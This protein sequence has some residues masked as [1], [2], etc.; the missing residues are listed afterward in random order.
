MRVSCATGLPSAVI[1]TDEVS[2]A[3]ISR[4]KVLGAFAR[5]ARGL[6]VAVAE[7]GVDEE[8]SGVVLFG[9][10]RA[11]AV[12]DDEADAPDG[13]AETPD[14]AS[15]PA[16]DCDDCPGETGELVEEDSGKSSV[17]EDCASGRLEAG[18]A[19]VGT[20]ADGAGVVPDDDPAVP[21]ALR[22]VPTEGSRLAAEVEAGVPEEDADPEDAGEVAP[23]AAGSVSTLCPAGFSGCVA[24]AI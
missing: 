10:E 2:S 6:G 21:D 23:L 20:A 14:G 22:D 3:R 19:G 1:E 15:G 16:E 13:G 8:A 24:A 12:V 7:W 9:V 4:V 17:D 18:A 11:R 5:A